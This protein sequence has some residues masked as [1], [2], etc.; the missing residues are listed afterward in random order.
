LAN[1]AAT[2]RPSPCPTCTYRETGICASIFRRSASG[3]QAEDW[4]QFISAEPD[5]EI[6][7]AG[8]RYDQVFVLCSGWAF[9]YVRLSSGGRQILKFLFPGD[10]FSSAL[11]F[12]NLSHFSVK[13]LTGIRYGGFLR[14]E[15]RE[16]CSACPNDESG[17][18]RILVDEVRDSAEYLAV[19][20]RCSAEQ[21]IAYLIQHLV[22][23]IAACYGIGGQRYPF[24]LK[25]RHIADSVGLTTVHVSRV[26]GQLRS[27]GILSLSEGTIEIHDFPALEQLGSVRQWQGDEDRRAAE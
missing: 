27:R 3:L 17:I 13:A 7:A 6:L 25:Q 18:S 24:P 22:R 8:G 10:V 21:R 14:S 2:A 19:L 11:I 9:Q 23:R 15:L 20:G 16:S 1:A 4:Q 12:E 5:R 26:L